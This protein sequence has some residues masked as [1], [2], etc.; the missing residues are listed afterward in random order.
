MSSVTTPTYT[1]N[2]AGNI[3]ASASLAASGTDNANVDYSAKWEGQIHVKNTPGGSVAATRGL[4]LS[5]DIVGYLL[6][7]LPR[8]MASLQ[9]IMEV[10]DQYSLMRKRPLTLPLVREALAQEILGRQPQER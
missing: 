10:L 4:Q 7:R 9:S 1:G 3:R 5:D 2:V 8:D 6:T